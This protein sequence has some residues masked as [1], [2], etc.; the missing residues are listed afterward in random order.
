MATEPMYTV[1]C[2]SCGRAFQTP[3]AF[4]DSAGQTPLCSFCTFAKGV[5]TSTA[6]E[7]SYVTPAER[8]AAALERIAAAL[9]KLTE[10]NVDER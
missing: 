8:Q 6:P 10:A 4:S 1:N 5:T 3:H 7:P 2:E 9:E